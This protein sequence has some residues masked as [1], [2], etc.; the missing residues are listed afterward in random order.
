MRFASAYPILAACLLL[1][2]VVFAVPRPSRDATPQDAPLPG[3]SGTSVDSQGKATAYY[4]DD[5]LPQHMRHVED[6]QKEFPQNAGY[7]PVNSD[8]EEDRRHKIGPNT[9]R[10]GPDPVTGFPRVKDEKP[11]ASQKLPPGNPGTTFQLL[12]HKES[13]LAPLNKVEQEIR[14]EEEKKFKAIPG[15]ENKEYEP[16]KAQPLPDGSHRSKQHGEL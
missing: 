13:G 14:K 3:R 5:F 4:G 6:N 1:H 16:S 15:N 8:G 11:L 2:D 9:M 10:A 12:S 7:F